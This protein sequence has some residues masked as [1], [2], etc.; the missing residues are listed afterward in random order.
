M[1]NKH[2]AQELFETKF[3]K[4]LYQTSLDRSLL[5]RIIAEELIRE[6]NPDI[7]SIISSLDNDIKVIQQTEPDPIDNLIELFLLAAKFK[8]SYLPKFSALVQKG[9]EGFDKNI[10]QNLAAATAK[11]EQIVDKLGA[12]GVFTFQTFIDAVKDE[13][14]K[15]KQDVYDG[16][17]KQP[18]EQLKN[19][20]DKLKPSIEKLLKDAISK[21]GDQEKSGE[22]TDKSSAISEIRKIVS[23]AQTSLQRLEGFPDKVREQLGNKYEKYGKLKAFVENRIPE[24]IAKIKQFLSDI[25]DK[26]DQ[27]ESDL[28]N[29]RAIK[30][31]VAAQIP[32]SI[33]D[34]VS[35]WK[36]L[37]T[38]ISEVFKAMTD[39]KLYTKGEVDEEGEETLPSVSLED[40]SLA[41]MLAFAM[42][43]EKD[44]NA[45]SIFDALKSSGVGIRKSFRAARKKAFNENEERSPE[46]KLEFQKAE[47]LFRKF[48]AEIA[49]A[50]AARH[51]NITARY[52]STEDLK[53]ALE[54]EENFKDVKL[55]FR[56]SDL[57]DDI[58]SINILKQLLKNKRQL[59]GVQYDIERKLRKGEWNPDVYEEL[60]NLNASIF[61]VEK[62]GKSLYPFLS[63]IYLIDYDPKTNLLDRE[64]SSLRQKAIEAVILAAVSNAPNAFKSLDLD[65]NKAYD[66]Y[67]K[68]FSAYKVFDYNTFN[69]VALQALKE[70]KQKNLEEEKQKIGSAKQIKKILEDEKL[71][72]EINS[73]NILVGNK[74]SNH[75]IK[76]YSGAIDFRK[77][78]DSMIQRARSQMQIIMKQNKRKIERA[79]RDAEW[80]KKL[81]R[82]DGIAGKFGSEE[83]QEKLVNFFVDTL[84]AAQK[85]R[86]RRRTKE[87][88]K[89][90]QKSMDKTVQD[91]SA[92]EK[93]REEREKEEKE[94]RDK[95]KKRQAKYDSR[96]RGK[97]KQRK[98]K[99]ANLPDPNDPRSYLPGGGL[100]ESIE[101]LI[102]LMLNEYKQKMEP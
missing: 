39:K 42:V 79:V 31:N 25:A 97:I 23:Q 51:I 32:E 8:T 67:A 68:T 96:P 28:A 4:A 11:I 56:K 82:S 101:K 22:I 35:E 20:Y 58:S 94:K 66:I 33:K 62:Y 47:D 40:G 64:K 34:I 15:L 10:R 21:I 53:G 50:F 26:K 80:A 83:Y 30:E 95:G 6:N 88:S 44:K 63:K 71:F 18:Q 89:S 38:E 52:S 70:R 19:L 29:L 24:T 1:N 3:I 49:L 57:A 2:L 84:D 100:E 5:N 7:N 60:L 37:E 85:L 72:A 76:K 17:K 73:I 99:K 43:Y 69:M 41:E 54:D 90:Q 16:L 61:D 12:P 93:E 78:I 81:D 92:K 91:F 27:I 14:F 46:E 77:L 55:N 45:Q 9:E 102:Y 86:N 65:S 74:I 36:T 98:R 48:E 13:N 75:I 87:F 59:Q